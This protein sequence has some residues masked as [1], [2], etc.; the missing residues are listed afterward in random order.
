M[1]EYA[2]L[3]KSTYKS[4]DLYTGRIK[5]KASALISVPLLRALCHNFINLEENFKI[6]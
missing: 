4:R 2:V 1:P 5:I 3:D 6:Q